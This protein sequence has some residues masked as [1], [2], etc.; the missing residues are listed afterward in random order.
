MKKGLD[1]GGVEEEGQKRETRV[2]KEKKQKLVYIRDWRSPFS[3]GQIWIHL[4]TPDMIGMMRYDCKIWTANTTQEYEYTFLPLLVMALNKEL[5]DPGLQ[6]WRWFFPKWNPKA[7]RVGDV[8]GL[9]GSVTQLH[10]RTFP[11]FQCG[12]LEQVETLS[13]LQT[14][15]MTEFVSNIEPWRTC[16]QTKASEFDL[17]DAYWKPP[18]CALEV[19]VW[20]QQD[21]IGENVR[22]IGDKP[23]PLQSSTVR[24]NVIDWLQ[25][26]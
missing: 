6:W 21:W 15:W 7:T 16:F 17:A 20:I 1:R 4:F 26:K 13:P 25:T 3:E 12:Y 5:K 2:V 19:T 8:G 9:E 10:R 11:A 18:S 14:C 23:E 22:K 24:E